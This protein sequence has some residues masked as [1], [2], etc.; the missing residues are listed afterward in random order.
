MTP[1]DRLLKY[2]ER[3][4]ALKKEVQAVGFVCQGSITKRLLECGT[5]GCRCHQAPENRHGPYHYWTRKSKGKTVGMKL[6]E[7]EIPLY[8]EWI[9]NNRRLGRLLQEMRD[10]SRRALALTTGRKAP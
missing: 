3:Y 7:D 5:A 4:L 1:S 6:T 8:R 9:D 2:S 10:V